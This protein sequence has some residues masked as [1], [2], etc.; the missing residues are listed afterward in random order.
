[1]NSHIFHTGEQNKT[2]SVKS[3]ICKLC[4]IGKYMPNVYVTS[5]PFWAKAYF[6]KKKQNTA[7]FLVHIGIQACIS[8]CAYNI[9]LIDQY[10]R[11]NAGERYRIVFNLFTA[12]SSKLALDRVKY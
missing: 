1:M 11:L 5:L 2:S 9:I 7:Y 6:L 12:E 8:A 4:Y 10:S 3:K